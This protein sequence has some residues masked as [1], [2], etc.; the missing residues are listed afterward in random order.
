MYTK[1]DYDNMR[2]RP[3]PQV[4]IQDVTPLFLKALAF[5]FDASRLPLLDR[6]A[7]ESLLL[8]QEVLLDL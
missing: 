3:A 7:T 4:H 5:G 8:A 6:P 1:D 2:D